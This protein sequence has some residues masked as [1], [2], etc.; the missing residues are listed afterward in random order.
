MPF[1]HFESPFLPVIL[2]KNLSMET[3]HWAFLL[4]GHN[5][6]SLRPCAYLASLV[7]SGLLFGNMSCNLISTIIMAH[8]A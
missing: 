7:S 5:L 6:A 4:H 2:H 3:A 1:G 8:V